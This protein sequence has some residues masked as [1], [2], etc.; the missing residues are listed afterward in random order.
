MPVENLWTAGTEGVRHKEELFPYTE[1]AGV[2]FSHFV[3]PVSHD[4]DRSLLMFF[5]CLVLIRPVHQSTLSISPFSNL[6][7]K[8]SK[9]QKVKKNDN[10]NGTTHL[11]RAQKG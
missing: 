6:S 5:V 1:L 3:N 8:R 4:T 2:P 9:T 11:K 10:F 7:V